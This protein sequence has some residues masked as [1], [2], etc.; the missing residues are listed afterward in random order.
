MKTIQ[1]ATLLDYFWLML[2]SAIWGSAFVGIGY[3]LSAFPPMIVA[4]YRILI[5]AVAIGLFVWVKR[6]PLPRDRRSWTLLG[7]LG[8]VNNALPFYLI[9]WGQ[10]YVSAS[11]AAVILAIGPFVALLM[12]HWL[13]HDEKITPFKLVGVALGFAGVFILFGEDFFTGELNSLYGK[14]AILI[15]TI[16]Y[17]SSGLMIRRLSHIDTLVCAGAMFATAVLWMLPFVWMVPFGQSGILSAPFLTILYLALI[18]TALASVIR[19]QLVQRTG[20]QFM[21]QVSYL[22]PLFAIFW[23]WV[24]LGE[25]PELIVWAALALILSGLFIRK[26]KV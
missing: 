23:A 21:S 6:L 8:L 9:S 14:L 10:Q 2:L 24:F 25:V 15:A 19:I 12:A 16:G 22:I 7:V 26:L 17:V 4:F 11:T 5:A 18:P 3:A 1:N 13:T 20:V